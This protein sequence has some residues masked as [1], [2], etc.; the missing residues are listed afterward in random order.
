M[1]KILRILLDSYPRLAR[2]TSTFEEL[3][4]GGEYLAARAELVD[5]GVEPN[6][7]LTT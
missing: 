4:G 1:I 3:D 5:V 7:L 6:S 2:L